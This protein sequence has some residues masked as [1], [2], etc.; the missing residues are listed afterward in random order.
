MFRNIKKA[1]EFSL[2]SE[3]LIYRIKGMPSPEEHRDQIEAANKAA[4]AKR[5]ALRKQTDAILM[6]RDEKVLNKIIEAGSDYKKGDW[7]GLNDKFKEEFAKQNV[8]KDAAVRML[9]RLQKSVFSKLGLS[10]DTFAKPDGQLGPYTM[11]AFALYYNL[12][13]PRA[14]VPFGSP[15]LA[16]LINKDADEAFVDYKQFN[17]VK[18]INKADFRRV[19]KDIKENTSTFNSNTKYSNLGDWALAL[20]E[21]GYGGDKAKKIGFPKIMD[22]KKSAAK[23]QYVRGIHDKNTKLVLDWGDNRSLIFV[24]ENGKMFIR[25]KDTDNL[26]P[27]TAVLNIG[28]PFEEKKKGTPKP[29]K[30]P[31]PAPK[32]Q[33]KPQETPKE[34]AKPA[35]V[36]NAEK[37][38]I[39]IKAL[40]RISFD[41]AK[42]E[43]KKGNYKEAIKDFKIADSHHPGSKPK[44]YIALCYDMM[45]KEGEKAREAYKEFES[46]MT[47]NKQSPKF[48]KDFAKEIKYA[49]GRI[50]ALTKGIFAFKPTPPPISPTRTPDKQAKVQEKIAKARKVIK[51]REEQKK[52]KG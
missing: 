34:P 23:Y 47:K 18:N 20:W 30:A 33:P 2:L 41:D 51:A 22:Y 38:K 32:P 15:K 45:G 26:K 39:Y 35:M 7:H 28:N 21:S 31:K 19:Y 40:A 17:F 24:N 9:V 5:D 37:D 13:R 25:D 4:K 48:L 46:F 16:A 52:K 43:M 36:A 49:K 6:L 44:Y 50:S 8:E 42:T 10:G 27:H 29:K 14:R 11:Y 1:S 12:K 3:K